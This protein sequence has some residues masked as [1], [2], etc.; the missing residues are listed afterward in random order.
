MKALQELLCKQK[1]KIR[2]RRIKKY[3]KK[4]QEAERLVSECTKLARFYRLEA[5]LVNAPPLAIIKSGVWK[6]F[7][8]DYNTEITKYAER[9][10]RLMQ[11]EIMKG[12]NIGE[13]AEETLMEADIIGIYP[14]AVSIVVRILEKCWKYGRELD[15]WFRVTND[16][17][18][19]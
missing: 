7:R 5:K 13:I 2:K 12:K 6:S 1:E 4:A 15:E 10:G 14:F 19:V 8:R 3:L 11:L 9:C 18:L 16:F 17:P